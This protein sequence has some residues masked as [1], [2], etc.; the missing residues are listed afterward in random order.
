MTLPFR[1]AA[2][3]NTVDIP[4]KLSVSCPA[5][6]SHDA[7]ITMASVP[8]ARGDDIMAYALLPEIAWKSF[9]TA[10]RLGYKKLTPLLVLKV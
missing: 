2:S 5:V 10:R 3:D 7:L 8:A 9:I 1:N 4:R 6:L